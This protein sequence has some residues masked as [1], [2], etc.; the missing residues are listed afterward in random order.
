MTANQD[1][2]QIQ[3]IA[4]IIDAYILLVQEKYAFGDRIHA[5]FQ[6]GKNI[7]IPLIGCFDKVID[8]MKQSIC[9]EIKHQVIS[10]VLD[11]LPDVCNFKPFPYKLWDGLEAKTSK[12][13][14][15]IL[16]QDK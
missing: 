8:L 5:A 2:M 6:M 13:L 14:V 10:D 15:R 1:S 7:D 9:A 11:D 12:D 16:K 3:N 4:K